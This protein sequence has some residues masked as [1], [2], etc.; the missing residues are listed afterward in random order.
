MFFFFI[1]TLS[2]QEINNLY[3]NK[4]FSSQDS[5]IQLENV[6]LNSSFFEVLDLEGKPITTEKY[7]IDFEKG[8]LKLNNISHD[9][10]Q[11][12]YLK[13][14][15]FLTKT[16]SIYDKNRMVSNDVGAK[17]FVVPEKKKST[18]VPFDGL[19]TDGSITRGITVGNNQ[20]MV[21]NSN[22][23]L[24]IT[25]KLS[26][27]VSLRASIQDSNVPLQNGGYSQKIDEFDQI[28]IELFGKDWSI[29]AGDLFIENRKSMY[30]N[31]NKK[32]QGIS[33]K[34]TF[35]SEKS[36]TEIEAAAA[37][38]RGQYAKSNFIGQE[39]NQ[40]PYKLKGTNG[41]L[42]IL[43]ISGSE[44]VYVNGRLLTRGENNDYVIDYNS[45][46]IRFTS[47]FPI[48]ADMRIAI[49]YQY[50]DRNYTRYLGY[51]GINHKTKSWDFAGYVYTESDIKNQPLQ[52]NLNEEQIKI[53]QEAGNDIN[54]MY[55]P[56]AYEDAYSENK[57]LYKKEDYNGTEIF[58][59][60]NNPDDQLY[61]VSFSFMGA[62]LGNYELA[63]TS[64]IG[65]IYRFVE[66][67]GDM[68]QG[69][70]EPV[71]R[72]IAPTKLTVAT[73]MTKYNPNEKTLVNFEIAMSNNDQNLFSSIDD[74]NN[75]GWAGNING[76]QRILSKKITLDAFAN[77]QFVHKNFHPIERLYS[78]EF[79]RD[80][81]LETQ[82][83]NQNIITAGLTANL[84]PQ[85]QITYQFDRLEFTKSY[86][87]YKNTLTANYNKNGFVA[88]TNSSLLTA[89]STTNQTNFIRSNS[90]VVYKK[91][92][93]WIGL[94]FD[95]EDYQVKNKDS[96][97][98]QSS[99][100]RFFQTDFFIGRGD[101]TKMYIELGYQF[102]A[103]DSLQNN[104]LQRTT[105]ANAFYVKS[106][107]F[108]T[109]TSD[110][111]VYA[112]YRILDYKYG[113]LPTENT[114][115]SRIAYNDRFF[116]NLIQTATVYE[117]TSGSIAQQEFTYLE[118][119]AGLGT[120]MWNDYNGNGI[121]ELEEFEVALFPDQAKYVRLYLPNQIYLRTHQ[122]KFSEALNINF[123]IW[124]NDSGFKKWISKF[125][126]Q[127]TYIIDK[128]VL[129]NG[130]EIQWNPFAKSDESLVSTNENFRNNFYFNRSKQR[131]STTYSY[132][133]NR[134][135]NL[136]NSGSVEGNLKT[137]QFQFTHL[138][139]KLWLFNFITKAENANSVSENYS[140]KNYQIDSYTLH[141][142]VSYLFSTQAS[143][144]IFYE[145]KNKFN[146][147]NN[148]E[149][150]DQHRIG[151]SF[152]Y[153]SI[154]KFSMNGEISY[155][156][157]NF[158][159]NPFS[160]VAFQMLEGLQPGKNITWRLLVQRNLT[161]YLDL[162]VNYQGRTSETGN[163]IHTGTIQLRAF[164]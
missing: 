126:N 39:G 149:T 137:H 50:T 102:R 41:E 57:V 92:E 145:Y 115:N 64:G 8:I 28:F 101:S 7:Q 21:T 43:I 82:F 106:Q 77:M 75:K 133:Q 131:Y 90:K 24:Q 130:Q 72:L 51:G 138:V 31:F 14:P 152:T 139:K 49:E 85:S 146:N 142:K 144:D 4:R 34:F 42:Y 33:T 132:I 89:N 155:Y 61:S 110:L 91:N 104:R 40:G 19:N 163:T 73:V 124:Q 125:H 3:Q 103:N 9:S 22:L 60:S 114:L 129:R 46:E 86:E 121:Q 78:I 157:N 83:G 88:Q 23:D 29:K 119:E 96:R 87:G 54:Q 95:L 53:L 36:K 150:L 122:T 12:N 156:E 160:P 143:V 141:P 105:Q 123:S 118:V 99:S 81:N 76:K 65:K 127:T 35:E 70:Y 116:K 38:A 135:K 18:Y 5:I 68:P 47:L 164:F 1:S 11:V 69:S 27:K 52:Q 112:N 117:N 74:Q 32:V 71:S 108:K 15:D 153:N 98:F 159:G 20:N 100:Q 94:N 67:I 158:T 62:N 134:T 37:L 136:L 10:I 48:T 45:G 97:E 109:K 58:V 17:L 107:V 147:L 30:M 80:W 84:N 111:N 161:K 63:S 140:E 44:K 128:N 148:Q 13:Y 154:K 162:N 113:N 66:P 59:Y 56:S 26:E 120:H 151:A 93:K 79:D 2:A 16:Y 25:G 6:A 55:A